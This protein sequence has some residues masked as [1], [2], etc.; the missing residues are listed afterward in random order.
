[1]TTKAHG[2]QPPDQRMSPADAAW[3]HMG[4]RVNQAVVTGML[5]S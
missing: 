1:M 5:L 3:L 2:E 4:G